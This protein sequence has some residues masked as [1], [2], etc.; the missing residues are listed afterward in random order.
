M[1]VY[2][3]EELTPLME[4]CTRNLYRRNPFRVLGL[5]VSASVPQVTRRVEEIRVTIETNKFK[6]NCQNLFTPNLLP[7]IEELKHAENRLQ[8]PL[9]RFVDEFFWFWPLNWNNSERDPALR[10]WANGDRSSA[11]SIWTEHLVGHTEH[12][13]LVAMHNLAVMFHLSA[14]EMERPFLKESRP[15]LQNQIKVLD[16]L[17]ETAFEYWG[18]LINDELFWSLVSDRIRT[19]DDPV[20]FTGFAQR[21]R[22]HFPLAFDNINTD[23]A[24]AYTKRGEYGR[25]AIHIRFMQKIHQGLNTTDQMLQT[26]TKPLNLLIDLAIHQ[27]T[28]NLQLDCEDTVNQ[29]NW[30]L[31]ATNAPLE[32]LST[33]LGADHAEVKNTGDTIAEAFLSRMIIYGNETNDWGTCLFLLCKGQRLASSK[34]LR[35]RYAQSK[36]EAK[37]GFENEQLHTIC[38]F[39]KKNQAVNRCKKEVS[40]HQLPNNFLLLSSGADKWRHLTFPVPRCSLC[41]KNHLL[42][43][44]WVAG[45]LLGG[46]IGSKAKNDVLNS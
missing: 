19:L 29:S 21:F 16:V 38:W 2:L 37:Y 1:D 18:K 30:L 15:L 25:A 10:A 20:F 8:D 12:E 31:D 36:A 39:C 14:I 24:T 41:Q 28:K 35:E 7:T 26:I 43:Y 32:A 27:V 17:W 40:I 11:E 6:D 44:F 46:A 4:A 23:F 3:Q 22:K 33:L 13:R 42:M 34:S 45:S 5:E 9:K